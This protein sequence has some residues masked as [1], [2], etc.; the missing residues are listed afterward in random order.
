METISSKT[1]KNKSLKDINIKYLLAP[2]KNKDSF[3]VWLRKRPTS[4]GIDM[5][6]D[7]T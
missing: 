4:V 5:Y 2:S 6:K 7:I 1:F 3:S